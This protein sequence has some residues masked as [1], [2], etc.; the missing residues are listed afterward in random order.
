MAKAIEFRRSGGETQAVGKTL[1]SA[2]TFLPAGCQV[3]FTRNGHR[4]AATNSG[5]QDNPE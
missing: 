4:Q 1:P 2:E 5:D 3:H